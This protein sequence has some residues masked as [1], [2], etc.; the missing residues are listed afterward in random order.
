MGICASLQYTTNKA[1]M[2]LINWQNATQ[3]I[4]F[5]GKLQEYIHPVKSGQVLS[6][7][8]NCFLCSSESMFVGAHVPQLPTNEELQPGQIYF[9][10]PLSQAKTPLSLQDL[11]ALAIKA[12]SALS[13]SNKRIGFHNTSGCKISTKSGIGEINRRRI[14]L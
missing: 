14:E 12:S 10:L 3:I 8:P 5:E 9:L 4:H 13:A 2:S 6:Q 11:C 1:R 7:N